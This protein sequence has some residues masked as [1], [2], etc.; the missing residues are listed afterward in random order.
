[1]AEVPDLAT[2][3]EALHFGQASQRQL[4]EGYEAVGLAG[5]GV[6]AEQT[7]LVLD[8]ADRP[9]GDAGYD[10]ILDLTLDVKTARKPYNLI[11]E[12]GHVKADLYALARYVEDGVEWVGWA[13]GREVLAAPTRDF[14]YGVLSHYVP[15]ED[16]R[17]MEPL[18]ALA[19]RTARR[20]DG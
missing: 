10:F 15:A 13:W 16:L 14:G 3:R 5:E 1:M 11:V 18:L 6:F 20:R 17:P 19:R 4:S 7:G 12:V 2:R 8:E 9:G